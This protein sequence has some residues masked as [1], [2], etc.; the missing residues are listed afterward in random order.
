M[1]A[2]GPDLDYAYNVAGEKAFL[3]VMGLLRVKYGV[4]MPYIDLNSHWAKAQE[5]LK[6]SVQLMIQNQ[7]SADF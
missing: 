5:K 1:P 6:E 7:H 4:H 2:G 3:E